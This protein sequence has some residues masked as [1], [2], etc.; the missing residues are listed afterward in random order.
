MKKENRALAYSA[1]KAY[2][3]TISFAAKKVKHVVSDSK[4]K[5]FPTTQ[6]IKQQWVT[7]KVL[8]PYGLRKTVTKTLKSLQIKRLQAFLFFKICQN[9]HVFA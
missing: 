7:N 4:S 8:V 5:E 1:P 6:D 3:Y 9:M 2:I